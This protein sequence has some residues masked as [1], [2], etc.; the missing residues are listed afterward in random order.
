MCFVTTAV[1]SDWLKKIKKKSPWK[2]HLWK[3]N[4]VEWHHCHWHSPSGCPVV[5]LYNFG[6]LPHTLSCKWKYSAAL[7]T[8]ASAPLAWLWEA[9]SLDCNVRDTRET[10]KDF[11]REGRREKREQLN[12]WADSCLLWEGNQSLQNQA[13]LSHCADGI[14]VKV[15]LNSHT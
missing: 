15:D 11:V 1:D 6:C 3:N 8:P 5:G 7:H 12:R 14:T 2:K 4:R 9:L 13:G 10:K